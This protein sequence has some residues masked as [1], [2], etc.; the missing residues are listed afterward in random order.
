M[1]R[2]GWACGLESGLSMSGG[3]MC[4]TCM[5]DCDVIGM[6]EAFS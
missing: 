6:G 2:G 5:L 3:I 4:V 1:L